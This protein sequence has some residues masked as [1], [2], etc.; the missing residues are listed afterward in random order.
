MGTECLGNCIIKY[1]TTKNR[2]DAPYKT[3]HKWCTRCSIFIKTFEVFC[4]CCHT[5]LRSKSHQY[6]S[7][8]KERVG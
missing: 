8:K 7:V 5:P 3:G 2:R 4:P 6:N 1:T